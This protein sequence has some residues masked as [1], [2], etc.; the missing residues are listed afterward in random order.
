MPAGKGAQ[1]LASGGGGRHLE[2]IAQPARDGLVAQHLE[3]A[4]AVAPDHEIR[5]QAHH[6][7]FDDNAAT[8]LLDRQ[9]AE[10][11][12]HAQLDSHI[13]YE[14][15]AGERGG[16]VGGGFELDAAETAWNLHLTSAPSLERETS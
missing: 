12:D 11:V 2:A 7:V 10:V 13:E 6:E 5:G 1:P 3:I 16:V 15:Q 9:G 4:E 8:T 14:L